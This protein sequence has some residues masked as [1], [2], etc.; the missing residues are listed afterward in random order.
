[1]RGQRVNLV[2]VEGLRIPQ[3]GGNPHNQR[4]VK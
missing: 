1:L 4:L 3:R 2:A